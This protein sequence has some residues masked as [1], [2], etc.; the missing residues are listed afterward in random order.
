MTS[1]TPVVVT[2]IAKLAL[3]PGDVILVT[4][5]WVISH[6]EHDAMMHAINLAFPDNRAL[7][8]YAGATVQVL[9]AFGV[10]EYD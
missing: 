5:P 1:R 9:S 3:Q 8:L 6:R 7:V 4:V 2:E 10:K